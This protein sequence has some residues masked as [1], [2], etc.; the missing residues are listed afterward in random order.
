MFFSV[1]LLSVFKLRYRNIV[2]FLCFFW[3]G[4]YLSCSKVGGRV[5][6]IYFC[7]QDRDY[8]FFIV[9]I[10][11]NREGG[12]IVQRV[13]VFGRSEGG[14]RIR[15]LQRGDSGDKAVRSLYCDQVIRAGWEWLRRLYRRFGVWLRTVVVFCQGAV[16]E[17]SRKFYGDVQAVVVSFFYGFFRRYGYEVG[18]GWGNVEV[19]VISYV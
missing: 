18:V 19:R 10:Y 12:I 5:Y 1:F 7:I 13:R 4:L 17:V 8:T 6:L 15:V 11:V 3:E 16:C 14:A 9:R 2:F